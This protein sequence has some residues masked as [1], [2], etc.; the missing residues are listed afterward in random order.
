[1]FRAASGSKNAEMGGLDKS[2]QPVGSAPAHTA[3]GWRD[4]EGRGPG[5]GLEEAAALGF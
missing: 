5:P 3:L 1:M 2:L 4:G